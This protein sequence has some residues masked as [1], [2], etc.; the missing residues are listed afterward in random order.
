MEPNIIGEGMTYQEVLLKEIEE[1]T[2][3]NIELKSECMQMLKQLA[4]A[5]ELVRRLSIVRVEEKK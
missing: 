4:E 5:S 3:K 2:L 1:L